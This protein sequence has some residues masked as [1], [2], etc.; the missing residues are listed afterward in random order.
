ML[1]FARVFTFIYTSVLSIYVGE[2]RSTHMVNSSS[3]VDES[4]LSEV[5]AGVPYGILALNETGVVVF[6][7]PSTERLLGYTPEELVD[8]SIEGLFS[9]DRSSLLE[10]FRHEANTT[11]SGG[12]EIP[13]SLVDNRGDDVP[14][15]LSVTEAMYD[16]QRYYTLTLREGVAE[17]PRNRRSSRDEQPLERIVEQAIDGIVVVDLEA[18]DIVECNRQFCDMLGYQYEELMSLDPGDLFHDELDWVRE[19]IEQDLTEAAGWNGDLAYDTRSGDAISTETF[20]SQIEVD[21]RPF[22][23]ATVRSSTRRNTYERQLK[24]LNDA[25]RRLM[26]ADTA[27]DIGDVVLEVVQTVF[28]RSLTAL[29]LYEQNNDVLRPLAASEKVSSLSSGSAIDAIGPITS[30]TTEMEIFRDGESELLEA[31][32]DVDNPAHPEMSL[33]SLLVVPLGG[34]GL[35]AIGSTTVEDID[36]SLRD[37]VDILAQTTQTAF[38]RLDHD[39]AIRHRSAAIDAATDSIGISNHHGE[40]TYANDALADLWG[41]DETDDLIGTTWDRLYADD[42]IERFESDILPVVQQQGQWRGEAVGK[43]TDGTTFPQEIS[44][45]A[46]DNGGLVCVIRDITDR[47]SQEQQLEML[48]EVAHELMKVHSREEIAE[49]GVDAIENVLGFEVACFRL[50]NHEKSILEPAVLTTGAERLVTSHIAYDLEATLAGRAFRVSEPVSTIPLSGEFGRSS[51][52]EYPSVHIPV[53]THGVVS[54]IVE[55]DDE[56]DDRDIRLAD[57]LAVAVRTAI[58]RTEQTQLLKEQEHELRQQRDQL[59]TLNRINTLI[60]LI[61]KKLVEATTRS[62]LESTICEQLAASELYSSAWIGDAEVTTD[63]IAARAG[64]GIADAD[65]K[66][67]NETPLSSL[68]NGTVERALETGDI[69]VIRQYRLEGG[70]T[71]TDSDDQDRQVETTAAVPIIYGD[72]IYGVM[73]V[74]G[75][76][77]DVFGE[78]AVRGFELLGQ[79]TG[80]AIS[81]IQNR[82]IL[83]SDSVVELE[84]EVADPRVFCLNVT[85]E[86]DCQCKLERSI[87]IDEGKFMHYHTITGAK[88]ADVLELAAEADHVE[89]ATAVAKRDDGFVLQSVTPEAPAE[90]ALQAGA[91]YQSAVAKDGR[92]RLVVEAPQSADIREIVAQL[93][94][95]FSTVDLR[96]KRERERSIHTADEFRDVVDAQLTEKQRTTIESAYFSGYYDWPREITAEELADSMGVSSSTLHQHLRNGTRHLLSAFFQDQDK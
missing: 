83:L 17:H 31:Y 36:R 72:R 66:A 42:E 94:E 84:F 50:L 10:Q 14:V 62:E 57:I 55:D 89:D 41:Y 6:A 76:N 43:R 47:K 38:K 93:E 80:F 35:L 24:A 21:D 40:F 45:S 68:G 7:T 52:V 9:G 59:E 16:D 23:L 85:K 2:T 30:E 15:W 54:I 87:P 22:L 28:G 3:L 53:G 71:D 26:D 82:K 20:V 37:L 4:F 33:K 48:N 81:A 90:T 64:S 51:P 63:R 86:L 96:S 78:K 73:V 12:S 46:L 8:R 25:S 92:G 44:L 58:E 95:G 49:I 13:L 65:L 5:I 34:Y 60:Q 70:V 91:T 77:E 56:V 29:W 11:T 67:I 88:P 32:D 18:D 27:H 39:Q 75:T 79:I 19:R 74:H 61:E 69:T 1:I